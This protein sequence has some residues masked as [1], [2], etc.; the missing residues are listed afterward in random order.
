MKLLE[1]KNM[2]LRNLIEFTVELPEKLELHKPY[3]A[4][5]R[6]G[7]YRYTKKDAVTVKE[8]YS[9]LDK[10][11]PFLTEGE[12]GFDYHLPKM[13][14]NV[15]LTILNFYKAVYAKDKTEASC[16][17]FYLHEGQTLEIPSEFDAYRVGILQ[18]GQWVL[19]CPQQTNHGTL[20]SFREDELYPYLRKHYTIMMETHSH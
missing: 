12:V 9:K 15:Y 20:T 13:P 2:S 16:H 11:M 7:V 8:F 19:Y 14:M 5:H 18:L 4:L 10:P 17:V 3:Y 6:D 1:D